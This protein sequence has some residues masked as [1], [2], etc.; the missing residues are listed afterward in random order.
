MGHGVYA[1]LIATQ[2]IVIRD[3][4]YQI[5]ATIPTGT[6]HSLVNGTYPEAFRRISRYLEP[7]YSIKK[8]PIDR[9]FCLIVTDLNGGDAI[10]V[11]DEPPTAI[12]FSRLVHISRP[13]VIK[14]A[15]YQLVCVTCV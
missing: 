6:I 15:T 13:V 10:Q 4:A 11:L 1:L 9:L 7:Y 12:E 14:G 5:Q 2:M 8:C 3:L